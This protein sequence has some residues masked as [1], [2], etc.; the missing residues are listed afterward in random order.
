M[1]GWYEKWFHGLR[2]FFSAP[3]PCLGDFVKSL[4]KSCLISLISR[5]ASSS[6]RKGRDLGLPVRWTTSR[7][8]SF[9][10][11]GRISRVICCVCCVVQEPFIAFLTVTPAT[12]LLPPLGRCLTFAAQKQKTRTSPALQLCCRFCYRSRPHAVTSRWNGCAPSC[13]NRQATRALI[14][15]RNHNHLE[16]DRRADR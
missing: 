16:T 2:F 5:T 1:A 8:H 12:N 15:A 13:G 9:G 7:C 14:G 4:P 11:S 6:V 10:P 3:A